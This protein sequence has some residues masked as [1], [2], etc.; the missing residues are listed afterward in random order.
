[1]VMVK[2]CA[3]GG[4]YPAILTRAALMPLVTLTRTRSAWDAA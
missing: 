2:Y 1:M 3:S 4:L